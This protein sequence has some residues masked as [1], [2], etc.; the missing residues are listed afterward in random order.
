M[1]QIGSTEHKK[2][3]FLCDFEISHCNKKKISQNHSLKPVTHVTL[4]NV[5]AMTATVSCSLT[6]C[7]LN[8]TGMKERP[9]TGQEQHKDISFLTTWAFALEKL[10]TGNSGAKSLSALRQ[11]VIY[12]LQELICNPAF[13]IMQVLPGGFIILFQRQT[14]SLI[15]INYL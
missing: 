7:S 14:S 15:V 1:Y 10:S 11:I 9:I 13:L 3:V 8:S 6:C 12:L 5:M 2:A 4:L